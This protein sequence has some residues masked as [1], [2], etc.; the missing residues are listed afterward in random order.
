MKYLI[1]IVNLKCNASGIFLRILWV[2]HSVQFIIIFIIKT[3]VLLSRVLGEKWHFCSMKL[4]GAPLCA[5][6]FFNVTPWSAIGLLIFHKFRNFSVQWWVW[7]TQNVRKKLLH[8][9]QFKWTILIKYLSRYIRKCQTGTYSVGWVYIW[10]AIIRKLPMKIIDL[11]Q[12]K[13]WF[14]FKTTFK[15]FRRIVFFFLTLQ[16]SSIYYEWSPPWIGIMKPT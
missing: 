2:V 13:Y 9:L 12:N 6:C 8:A 16:L 3:S 14:L 11:S 4:R 10:E 15:F 7:T 1:K 5:C